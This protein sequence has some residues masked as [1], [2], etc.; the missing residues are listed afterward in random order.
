MEKLSPGAH[1]QRKF[2]G[3]IADG[4]VLEGSWLHWHRP[5]ALTPP[6]VLPS[7]SPTSL[8]P[9]K[10]KNI[11]TREKLK[12][13]RKNLLSQEKGHNISGASAGPC[14]LAG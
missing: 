7:H 2:Q 1:T 9:S 4:C 10:K 3:A 13:T 6:S 12:R 14:L 11:I 5:N 8:F